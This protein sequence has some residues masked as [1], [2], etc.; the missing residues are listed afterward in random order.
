MLLNTE[1]KNLRWLK[2]VS[3]LVSAEVSFSKSKLF[4]I[5]DFDNQG[6]ISI[7][8]IKQYCLRHNKPL[9]LMKLKLLFRRIKVGLQQRMGV[10]E[11]GY[12]FF[13]IYNK[14]SNEE[15]HLYNLYYK[16]PI[17]Q[18]ELSQKD[19]DRRLIVRP[20]VQTARSSFQVTRRGSVMVE[21]DAGFKINTQNSGIFMY[22]RHA[23][24]NEK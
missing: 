8:N 13:G 4:Q 21:Q 11:F 24:T 7:N 15:R 1:L 20:S 19:I 2:V 14:Q 12:I 5:L 23:Y 6:T 10:K 22:A 3:R 17:Q 18:N 16:R 9:N